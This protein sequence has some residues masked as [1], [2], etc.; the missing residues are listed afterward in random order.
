M[1][2]RFV[3]IGL[4]LIAMPHRATAQ[5]PSDSALLQ[6]KFRLVAG[7]TF[8][9]P[10]AAANLKTSYRTTTGDQLTVMFGG[11]LLI[12]ATV[13]MNPRA[14]PKQMDYTAAAPFAPTKFAGL[15]EI[16]GDTVRL[17]F[18]RPDGPRPTALADGPDQTFYVWVRVQP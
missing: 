1:K 14:R 15:Y 12:K 2:A 5:T 4:A 16:R 18:G 6:G 13:R 17:C 11:Q 10:V 9:V 3:A 8:G 7:T